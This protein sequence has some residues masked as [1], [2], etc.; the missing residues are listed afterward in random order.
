MKLVRARVQNYRSVED[1]GEFDI[2][3]LTC[4]VGKNEAGKTAI[5]SALRALKP[6]K[7]QAFE[8][9]ETI[10]YPRRFATRFDDRH[11]DGQAEVIRTWW[12]LDAA[13]ITTVE[14]RFGTGAL[15]SDSFQVHFGFRYEE[16]KRHWVIEV[17]DVKC[18]E[19]LISKHALDATERNVLHGVADGP[20]ADKALSALAE[21][22][23]KQESLLQE[24]KRCRDSKFILG[25]IDVL[26]ERQPRFFF[27]SHFERMSGM[28]SLNQ[29]Q[30][31][32]QHNRVTIGDKIFL[33]FLEYAGTTLEELIQADRREALKAKCEAAS[34]EITE[35]I[36]QFWSQNNA[37]EVVI[38]IDSGKASDPPPFN[39]GI[40][41][42]I[43]IRNT[44]HKA[45]LPLSERSAGFVWFFSFLAQFKQLKK[46]ESNAIILLDEPGLTLH[47]KAQG[48]LLRYIVERLLPDHQVIF[49]THSPFMV[50][51]DRLGDV[52]IVEDVIHFNPKT[53]RPDLKGTKIHADVLEVSDDTLFPLQGALGYEVTQSMFIGAHTWLV[54]GPS[55][56][57]YLQTLSQAL[58]KRNRECMDRRWTLC[59]SGGIDKIA[60]FVRLFGGNHIDIAVLSDVASSD[61]KK[62]EAVKKEQ[63][64][65]A[66][67]FFTAADF[68]GQQEADVEDLFDPAL[69]AEILNGA[70]KPPAGKEVT[71]DVLLA[72]SDTER[73][74][75]K[76]EALFKLMP[77][78]VAEFDH[79]GP[80]RWLLDNPQILDIDSPAVLSTLD[81]AE[82]IFATFNALLS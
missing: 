45:T 4:L 74:V 33:S 9:D 30:L 52:R 59:P 28:V 38:E 27:T 80:A 22:S 12:K 42:D 73:I 71:K 14:Q 66:G 49:T 79:F 78:E 35:E 18:L 81:K 47:G 10:D 17:D 15:K 43:R 58:R 53:G 13:D 72:A 69:F 40:V 64:L 55:D 32:R 24:I 70:Y 82:K 2:G 1:S 77:P 41:A 34:N 19:H 63:I 44:N 3:E 6:S 61:K 62:I 23:P 25:V 50:P 37:L 60:P 51:M 76:A 68:A 8:I 54:E 5:L 16:D 57:L 39:S 67:H 31:D 29:L 48:D 26:A 11:P 46:T 56:I 65:K 20:A 7:S 36:F 21:R 75:K